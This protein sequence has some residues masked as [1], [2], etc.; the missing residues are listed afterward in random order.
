M[1]AYILQEVACIKYHAYWLWFWN[2][3]LPNQRR[4]QTKI[5]VVLMLLMLLAAESADAVLLISD[6]RCLVSDS[7]SGVDAEPGA[8]IH[9]A[10]AFCKRRGLHDLKKTSLLLL[11]WKTLNRWVRGA[12]YIHCLE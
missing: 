10:T 5:K 7:D 9:K 3:P 8:T 2:P 4:V 11:S 12:K 6:F 1:F